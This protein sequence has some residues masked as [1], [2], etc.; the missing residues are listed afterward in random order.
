MCSH[1]NVDQKTDYQHRCSI[2]HNKLKCVKKSRAMEIVIYSCI[3]C[4]SIDLVRILSLEDVF[5]D[6]AHFSIADHVDSQFYL[7]KSIKIFIP[8]LHDQETLSPLSLLSCQ[9][10]SSFWVLVLL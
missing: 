8:H 10:L 9:A 1:L 4:R 3:E 5:L 2:R 7:T 6:I